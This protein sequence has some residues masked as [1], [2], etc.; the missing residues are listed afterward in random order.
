M[1]YNVHAGHNYK[2]AGAH[3]IIKEEEWTRKVTDK[4][5]W[6][7]RQAGHTVYDCTDNDGATQNQNLANIVKKCNQHKV[8][9]D[10]SIH[11]NSASASAT[12]TEV[13][14]YDQK[15][16][17]ERVSEAVA[18]TL[19]IRNRGAKENKGLYVL[20]NTKSPAILIEVC[21]VTNAGDVNAIKAKLAPVGKAIAE[22]ITG[23]T[24]TPTPSKPKP[25][26]AP[27]GDNYTN[28]RL[29]S[30]VN[31]LRF[32]SKPS[33]SDKDVVGTCNKGIGF[34]TIVKKVKVADAYQ[35]QVKNSKGAVFYIT[36]S[37][38]YVELKNK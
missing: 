9:L 21:F 31:N 26:P 34:P 6:F 4:V 28:K 27:S 8:T 3:G 5:I 24:I 1:I 32:Y 18:S 20:R 14:Y 10:V 17:A 25:S 23:K 22:A 2:V 16:T 35:Y 38:K 19:G 11:F 29:V 15:A 7:L 36:A 12:G 37:S 30:K 13:L 33:W